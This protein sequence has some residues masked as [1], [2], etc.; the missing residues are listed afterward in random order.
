MGSMRGSLSVGS[1]Y[2]LHDRGGYILECLKVYPD[3]YYSPYSGRVRSILTGWTMD[4]HGVNVYDDG[5]ID[6]DFSTNG[7][8]TEYDNKGNLVQKKW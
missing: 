8:F 1:M 7:I 2:R 5:S 4:I 6:W 3:D